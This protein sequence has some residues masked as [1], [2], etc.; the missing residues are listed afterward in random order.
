MAKPLSIQVR[1]LMHKHG[2][3]IMYT[4]TYKNFRTIKCYNATK[5]LKEDIAKLLTSEGLPVIMRGA[6]AHWRGPNL[7]GFIVQLPLTH[8]GEPT[9]RV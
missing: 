5:E 2:R 1:A 4:N 9:V 8:N 6:G 7:I 3:S